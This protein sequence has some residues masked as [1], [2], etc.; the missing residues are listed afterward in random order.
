L[1]A[2]KP[3][4]WFSTDFPLVEGSRL[5]DVRLPLSRGKAGWKYLFPI[6]GE[7]RLNVNYVTEEGTRTS[8]VFTFAIRE[9]G[10]KWL[11]LTAFTVGL[12]G[13]GLFAGRIFSA[14]SG[15]GENSARAVMILACCL[16]P[17][18]AGAV[19]TEGEG[20]FM[21]RLEIGP[22]AVG[23]PTSVKW[24]L[25]G[26]ARA[27]HSRAAFTLTVTH[28]ENGAVVFAVEKL[29]VE[30]EFSVDFHFTDGAEYRVRAVADLPP[31][32]SV[33]TEQILSVTGAEPPAGAS[34]PAIAFFVFVLAGGLAA[35][36][37]SR[38]RI[39]LFH[40]RR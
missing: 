22:A 2:P 21:G 36:R 37:W 5:I 1:E 18:H 30:R 11:F 4:R 32:R 34:L 39:P 27:T 29:P 35:G 17:A 40:L 14:A 16:V 38:G 24:R 7:Y 26:G 12:F 3:G 10:T 33:R 13:L 8:K 31:A 15:A 20:P 19:S 6:R 28:L 25:E 9:H 23:R